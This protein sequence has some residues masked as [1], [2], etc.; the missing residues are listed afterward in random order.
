M[1]RLNSTSS[2]VRA[3]GD[4]ARQVVQRHLPFFENCMRGSRISAGGRLQLLVALV[5]LEI[6]LENWPVHFL[7]AR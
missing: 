2:V 5:F 3:L 6:E 7:R 4:I 1:K